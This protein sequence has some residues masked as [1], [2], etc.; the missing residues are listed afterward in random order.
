[1]NRIKLTLCFMAAL[2][3]SAT[4]TSQSFLSR[5]AGVPYHDNEYHGGPQKIPG[6]VLCAYYDLGGEGIA[7]HDSDPTESWQRRIESG[8]WK[9]SQ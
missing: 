1:M 6:R 7:Y 4:A 2:M 5:Y 3:L 9:L 8:G